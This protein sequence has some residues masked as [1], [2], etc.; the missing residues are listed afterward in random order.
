MLR[1]LW[2]AATGLSAQQ[3]NVDVTANNLA[4]VNTAGFKRSRADFQ[5][6][7]YSRL[8]E[9]GMQA[10]TPGLFVPTGIQ[11]GNGVTNVATTISFVRGALQNTERPEDVSIQDDSSFFQVISANGETLYTR[12]G[13]F[14]RDSGGNIVTA[15]GLKLSP[16]LTVPADAV[17]FTFAPDGTVWARMGANQADQNIGQ[18]QLA[19]FPNPAGLRA[20]GG[21]LFVQTESSGQAQQG[22][23][24]SDQFGELQSSFLEMSNV[25]A[26]RELINLI[27]A[28]RAF[29]MNS[30]SIQTSDEMLQTTAALRR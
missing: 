30:R 11:V 20:L 28:Q 5:D 19:F 8:R 25:D 12:D 3:R 4:N 2:T 16:G 18:I 23:P 10:A 24:G 15:T 9:P 17:G 21:N 22:T 7:F 6:L 1:S 27:Q 14:H 29:E 26:A 13:N